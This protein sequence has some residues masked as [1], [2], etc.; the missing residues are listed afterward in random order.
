MERVLGEQQSSTVSIVAA[1]INQELVNRLQALELIAGAIGAPLL[2]QPPALQKYLEQRL[3]LPIMFNGGTFVAAVDGTAIADFPV[4]PGRVG[5][6]YIDRETVAVP[7][8]EGKSVIGRPAMGKKLLAPVFSIAVPIRNKQG[9]PVGVLVGTIDLARRNFL[10]VIGENRYGKSG[11]YLIVDARHKLFVTATDKSRVLQPLPQPGINPVLDKRIQG[12]DGPTVNVNS[13]GVEVL[14]SSGRVPAAGW[15]VISALPTQEA[16]APIHEMQRN[17]LLATVFLTLLA[18]IL[19]WWMLKRLL[20]PMLATVHTL[21]ELS[22][23]DNAP[24]PLPNT[25]QDEIGDL[26]GGFNHLLET[27]R[28]REDALHESERELRRTQILARSGNWYWDL[29]TNA[30]IWSE[31]IYSIYGRDPGLSPAVYPEVQQYFA[32]DSWVRLAA[33]VETC[34]VEGKSYTCDS[35]V[36]RPDGARRWVVV[37]GEA[38]RSEDGETVALR[39]TVQDITERKQAEADQRA[40]DDQLRA[41]YELDLVGLAIT[42]PEKGWVRV[43]HCLC[44]MLGY[45]EQDLRKMTWAQLTHPED[46]AADIEQF[47]R[48]LANEIDGY[49]L[50]KRFISRA[51]KIIPTQLV[52]RCTHK[53]NGEVDYVTAMVEDITERKCAE[54]EIR[55]LN[56]DLEQR[57]V[58]R[59]ANLDAAIRN[60]TGEIDERKR[61]EQA[62]L[63]S[64]K[65]LEAFSYSVA[66]DLRT[67]L[68]GIAGFARLIEEDYAANFDAEGKDA[69]HRVQDAAQKMGRLIDDLLKLSSLTRAEMNAEAVD[70]SVLA[71]AVV[72]ELMAGEPGRSATFE[73][74]PQLEVRGDKRLLAVLLDNLLGNA[75]KFTAKR[76]DARIELGVHAQDGKP[77]YYVR[78]NGVGFDM[79]HAVNLFRPFYRMHG[80]GEFPGTGIGLATV[81]R[82]VQSH[83]GRI[84]AEAAIGQGATF[85]FTLSA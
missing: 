24:Q 23:S 85:Y 12:F 33:A 6:N 3:L 81:Q 53:A 34:R 84:W 5:T 52:V 58:D 39:G 38:I 78:D 36:V 60:L 54:Q 48:I 7:L 75:W 16:F 31:A 73:I 41:F 13:A 46:L 51:G 72:D 57:V 77:A 47:S 83:G 25:S 1:Q 50:E 71:G 35:E 44:Q 28:Q 22:H 66:H 76:A 45:S 49:S 43:N 70:L 69:L 40:S 55:R 67:P 17:L 15:F 37:N 29:R 64:N 68:R 4:V 61:V 19:T 32:P 56:A 11:G 80:A 30:H 21:A 2:E 79:A 27:L 59:T 42:S 26:I 10:D 63:S 62:L 18:G 20:A 14:S 8:K 9:T 74:P 82:I 65:E